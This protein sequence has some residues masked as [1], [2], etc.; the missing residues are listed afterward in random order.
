[1][2]S[3]EEFL[4]RSN[5]LI[6]IAV[7]DTQIDAEESLAL[8]AE[9]GSIDMVVMGFGNFISG[10]YIQS[11]SD[12]GDVVSNVS[13]VENR[14]K[15]MPYAALNALPSGVWGPGSSC[16]LTDYADG[17]LADESLNNLVVSGTRA[18][19]RNHA[20][21]NS[22]GAPAPTHW[23]VDPAIHNTQKIDENGDPEVDGDGNPV[24]V[25][26]QDGTTIFHSDN[27]L[28][29]VILE[30]VS[31]AVFKKYGR[32]AAL[33]NDTTIKG[34]QDALQTAIQEAL[35]EENQN[36][37]SSVMFKRY[38]DSGRYYHDTSNG[39]V[40]GT[41]AYEFDQAYFDFVIKVTGKLT[42]ADDALNG[43]AI[44]R[45]LGPSSTYTEQ[46]AEDV[47]GNTKV[48]SGSNPV[49]KYEINILLRLKQ[50]DALA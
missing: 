6:T 14:L 19:I 15:E 27:S 45:I 28:G 1:M 30:A 3:S 16:T 7:G 4:L 8:P 35:K 49:G 48:Q 20:N 9:S 41:H 33:K 43:D 42:D 12:M 13:F 50:V 5:D 36:Y 18:N 38:L 29:G 11:S 25:T 23:I 31:G 34:N 21:D 44:T 17:L 37:A 32:H 22:V 40:V 46:G 47:A 2:A 39:D 10:N 26:Y 24:N